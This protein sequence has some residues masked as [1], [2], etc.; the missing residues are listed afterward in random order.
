[1]LVHAA[2]GILTSTHF[3]PGRPGNEVAIQIALLPNI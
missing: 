3:G 2:L 1:M